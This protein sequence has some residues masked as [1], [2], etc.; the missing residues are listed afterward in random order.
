V[1][2]ERSCDK[3]CGIKALAV[4]AWW[5]V[6]TGL[7]TLA[8]LHTFVYVFIFQPRQRKTF[9]HWATMTGD[10]WTYPVPYCGPPVWN[11]LPDYICTDTIKCYFKIF[12]LLLTLDLQRIGNCMPLRRLRYKKLLYFVYYCAFLQIKNFLLFFLLASWVESMAWPLGHNP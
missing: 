12:C 6:C 2:L 9:L 11:T 10:I 4:H 1:P 5:G 3:R 7:K 8:Y